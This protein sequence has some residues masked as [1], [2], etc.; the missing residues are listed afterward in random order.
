MCSEYSFS[1]NFRS[2]EIWKQK[3]HAFFISI[4]SIYVGDNTKLNLNYADT[5]SWMDNNYF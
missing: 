2:F 5:F 4:I 1:V 3:G